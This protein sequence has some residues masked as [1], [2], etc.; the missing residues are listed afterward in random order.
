MVAP[1]TYASRAPVPWVNDAAARA[2]SAAT[3][4][5]EYRR[6]RAV[7]IRQ[8]AG[9]CQRCGKHARLQCDHIVPVSHGGTHALSNLQALCKSCHG[10]KTGEQHGWNARKGQ[11]SDPAP[12]S[13][14]EW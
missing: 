9:R 2:A 12:I 7:I 10:R 14:T 13:R 4:G 11:V 5:P 1:K 3:Y 6:N 8:A